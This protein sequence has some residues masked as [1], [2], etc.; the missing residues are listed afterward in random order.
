MATKKK[1]QS[2]PFEV[3]QVK[4][5]LHH[6]LGPTEIARIITKADGKSRFSDTA[7][8]NIIAKLEAQ[9]TW[10]GERQVGSGPPRKTT[11]EEDA[12]LVAKVFDERG[13]RKVTVGYLRTQYKFARELGHTA[14][15]ERLH[16]AELAYLRRR[17][18]S[19]VAPCHLPGRVA[20]LLLQTPVI[21]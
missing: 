2:T 6:G 7:V 14:I 17:R 10:R 3:G 20:W 15:E 21:P 13:K 11:E 4:A 8:A 12:A 9:P 5:H 1:K 18:K 16:D 19:C